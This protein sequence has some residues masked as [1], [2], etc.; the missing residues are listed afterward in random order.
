MSANASGIHW[1]EPIERNDIIRW[2][3]DFPGLK[4][5]ENRHSHTL[6]SEIELR[7]WTGYW[8]IDRGVVNTVHDPFAYRIWVGI[9]RLRF[10]VFTKVI[11]REINAISRT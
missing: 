11:Q 10:E 1:A 8:I 6:G 5:F 2:S 3:I 4:R 9:I 7:N